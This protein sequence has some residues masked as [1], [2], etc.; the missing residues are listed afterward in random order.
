MKNKDYWKKRSESIASMQYKKVDD[1]LL[2][3][4]LEYDEALANIKKDIESFYIRFAN[5]NRISLSEANKLLNSNQLY[6]FKMDLKEF[7]NKAKDNIDGKW[8]QELNNVS[9]KVRISR[10]Q[11]LQTQLNNEIENLYSKQYKDVTSL[12][13]DVYEDTY[14]RNIYEVQKGLGVGV[15]FAK[16]DSNKIEKTIKEPWNG[17]NYSSRIWSNKSKLAMELQTNLVQSFIRGDSIDKTSKIIANRMNVS[18]NRART[19]VNTESSYITSKATFDSYSGSGVVKQYEILATLDLRTSQ[20]CREM[21]GKVFDLKDKLIGITAPPFHPNCRTTTVAYFPD[22]ID[23]ER[24][25][26]DSDGNNYVDGNMDYKQWYDRYVKGNPKEEVAEKKI[27]NKSNDIKQHERYKEILGENIPKSFDKF[28]ELKYNNKGDWDRISY[29]YKLETVYNLDRLKHTENFASKN[30]IKHIL[31]GEINKRG[32]AVGFHMEN[33]PT[34]K[35]EIIEETKSKVNKNGIYN[36]K[37]IIEG[38]PK[39]A[40]STFFPIDMTPQEIVNAINEAYYSR[41][42]TPTNEFI[43]NT[44]Y[45][46]KIGMYLDDKGN[47]MTAYPKF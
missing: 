19:L 11:A 17:D 10:L 12:L 9:Y 26:R 20:I 13:N 32:K 27:K 43:G 1:Y 46:F 8:E 36:A 29:K 5:N 41:I 16:L 15:N 14:Y 44:S 6:E 3:M 40:K 35:G 24:I 7:T 39:I 23:E 38:I 47:I 2:S 31:E 37:V 18:K 25:A 30:V 33:M 21:D 42:E 4:Q 45:G 22:S 34:K 28:Q